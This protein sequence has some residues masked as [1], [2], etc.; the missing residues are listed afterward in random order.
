MYITIF[1]ISVAS[2][3]IVDNYK[4]S[5][6]GSK[7]K[8]MSSN[9]HQFNPHEKEWRPC[10]CSDSIQRT[11]SLLNDEMRGGCENSALLHHGSYVR[12]GCLQFV[13]TVVDYTNN[14]FPKF[15]N[16][17][18]QEESEEIKNLKNV[19]DVKASDDKMLEK[20]NDSHEVENR[21]TSAAVSECEE[22]NQASDSMEIDP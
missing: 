18:K 6:T 11:M 12:F 1:F 15:N 20:K 7:L 2:K 19:N 21:E 4:P 22:S 8:T 14:D 5:I 16:S 17:E 13:F 3:T 10:N 9:V